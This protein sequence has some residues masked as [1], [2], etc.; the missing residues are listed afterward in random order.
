[1]SR[2]RENPPA[3]RKLSDDQRALRRAG[4]AA[5][6]GSASGQIRHFDTSHSPLR[7]PPFLRVM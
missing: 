2:N 4:A 1:M 5:A 3:E 7:L 6:R